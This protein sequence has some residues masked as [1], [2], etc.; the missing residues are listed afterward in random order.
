MLPPPIKVVKKELSLVDELNVGKK[1]AEAKSY[2]V[3]TNLDNT[4]SNEA[5]SNNQ[6]EGAPLLKLKADIIE[7]QERLEQRKAYIAECEKT[8]SEQSLL[9][10]ER[11]AKVEQSEKTK[12]ERLTLKNTN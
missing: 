12:S 9:L 8:L 3:L 1:A 5:K 7:H 2:P 4:S 10:A 6:S 11:K